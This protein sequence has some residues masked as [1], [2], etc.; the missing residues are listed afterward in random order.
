M[1]AARVTRLTRGA[2]A[3]EELRK[4]CKRENGAEVRR[5]YVS[6]VNMLP[7]GVIPFSAQMGILWSRMDVRHKV[8]IVRF[9]VA[10]EREEL[11][12]DSPE[13]CMK[14]LEL[15]REIANA[16]TPDC[17][18]VVSMD[19]RDGKVV[20]DILTNDVRMSDCKSVGL[21]ACTRSRFQH[22]VDKVYAAYA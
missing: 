18:S 19:A 13:D 8:E 6:S 17:Q 15:G 1:P 5:R 3:L 22:L 20:I 10:F 12:P 4:C 11:D 2:E 7:D 14:A 9:T 21:K 16:N